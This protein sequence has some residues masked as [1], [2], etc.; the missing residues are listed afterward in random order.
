[1]PDVHTPS[2]TIGP[3][4]GFAL[5][6]DSSENMV[7]PGRPD[8]VPLRGRV[9]DGGGA[10]VPRVLVEGWHGEMVARAQTNA[11][12]TFRMLVVKPL[13]GGDRQ[14]PHLNLSLYS[15]GLLKPLLTRMY[16]PDEARANADDPVLRQVPPGDRGTLLAVADGGG[17][18]FDIHLQGENETAFFAG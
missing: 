17:L 2:Q 7:P 6:F 4:Y 1:M 5:L 3:L 13:P 14:A 9:F 10:L 11:R 15:S 16:F 8:A 18:R 12:G